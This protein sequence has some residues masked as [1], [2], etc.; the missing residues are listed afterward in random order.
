VSGIKALDAVSFRVAQGRRFLIDTAAHISVRKES[1]LN[2]GEKYDSF[3]KVIIKGISTVTLQTLG[4]ATLQL[5]TEDMYTYHK[6]QVVS[7]CIAIPFDAI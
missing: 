6:F 5:E 4:S 2:P 3:D 1:R 7:D